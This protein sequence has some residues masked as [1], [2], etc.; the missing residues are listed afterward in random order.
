[1]SYEL[2][3]WLNSINL[4]KESL[5]KDDEN[6][7]NEY[8]PYLINKILAGSID[9]IM[10]VNEMN[11]YNTLDKKLQYEFYL[12]IIRKRKRYTP[13]IKKD[14]VDDLTSVKI[15][16]NYSEAKAKEVLKLLTKEQLKKIK[17]SVSKGGILS[18]S[19]IKNSK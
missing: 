3:D 12:N 15:Y 1:M 6:V 17:T 9:C 13:L 11:V 2:K 7:I 4:T 8:S 14:E 19:T 16:Y 10:Y 5:I 18:K